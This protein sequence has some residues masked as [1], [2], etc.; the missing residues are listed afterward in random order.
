MSEAAVVSLRPSPT[1]KSG[2]RRRRRPKS[3]RTIKRLADSILKT[4]KDADEQSQARREVHAARQPV[5]VRVEATI[6]FLSE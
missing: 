1:K 5:V 4:I 6:T 3:Q 2:R